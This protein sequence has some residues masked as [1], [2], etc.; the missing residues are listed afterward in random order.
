[1][2]GAA[3]DTGIETILARAIDAELLSPKS[4]RAAESL[5]ERFNTPTRIALVGRPMS[6][7]T[8]VFNLLANCDVLQDDANLGTIRLEFGEAECT[9]FQFADGST[10]TRHALPGN[11]PDGDRIP[12]LTRIEA[13]LP[14]LRKISLLQIGNAIEPGALQNALHWATGQSDIAIWCTRGFSDGE[15]LLWSTVPEA[16]TDHAILLRTNWDSAVED[17][18]ALEDALKSDAGSYFAHAL[19]ISAKEVQAARKGGIVDK[20]KLR[21]SGATRLIST[22]LKDLDR[23]RQSLVD[24]AELILAQN[25]IDAASLM[26]EGAVAVA[27][28]TDEAQEQANPIASVPDIAAAKMPEPDPSE[29]VLTTSDP[30]VSPAGEVV[31][32][33]QTAADRLQAVGRDM[34]ADGVEP[35]PE[36]VLATSADTLVWLDDCLA[37]PDLPDHPALGDMRRLT[38]GANDIVQLLRLEGDEASSIDAAVMLL[39]LRRSLLA[40]VA[41]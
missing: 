3:T 7:K 5:L 32:L 31:V 39:Q 28:R 2:K 40:Q 16:V 35:D 37:D 15:P 36:D 10:E 11:G 21:A 17:R 29:Q 26:S 38:Q 12:V 30:A 34:I 24:T 23:A 33:F 20:D 4:K 6:G 19:A 18:R 1:M 22:L 27:D 14:A 25:R 41:A 8:C 13:P 9:S